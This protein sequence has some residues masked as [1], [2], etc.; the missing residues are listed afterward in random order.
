M[1]KIYLKNGNNK[2][3]G[4]KY[5]KN[6]FIQVHKREPNIMDTASIGPCRKCM[7]FGPNEWD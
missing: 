3:K 6:H 5:C 1:D 4:N 7:I 2:R